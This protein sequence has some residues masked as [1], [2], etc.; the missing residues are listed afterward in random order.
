MS[1]HEASAKKSGSPGRAKGG[2]ARAAALTAEERQDIARKAALKRWEVQH[3]GGPV[4]QAE[5]TGVLTIGD[6]QIPCAV[7]TNGQRVMSDNG[8]TKALFGSPSG[9]SK[10]Q[11]IAAKSEGALLPLFLAPGNLNPFISEELREGPLKPILYRSGAR[12]VIGYSAELLPAVC[13]VWLQARQAGALQ[14]GQ[15]DKAQQAE[16]LMRS[17]AKIGVIA[18][19]D[20]ATGYQEIRDRV[21]LQMILDKYLKDEWSKWTRRFPSVF[22]SELFRLKGVSIAADGVQKPSYVGHW[23][24]DIVYS[25][26]TPGLVKKLKEINPRNDKGNRTRKHHQHFT[27]ELGVPELQTHIS[28]VVFLMK[29]CTTDEEF[30]LKLDMAAPKHGDTLPITVADPPSSKTSS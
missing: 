3:H 13:D 21:A 14:V 7:L 16:I 26:L 4:M 29:T 8:I 25:R 27:E 1:K 17:L 5:Y 18:L 9:A 19:V 15:M 30:K 28:N 23:T 10:R 20:E 22:Y 12:T 11:R 24:N 6:K 2:K